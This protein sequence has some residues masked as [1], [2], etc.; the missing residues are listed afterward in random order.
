MIINMKYTK[1]KIADEIAERCEVKKFE[2]KDA[3]NAIIEELSLAL[4]EGEEIQLRR[5]GTFKIKDT[6]SRIGRNIQKGKPIKIPPTKV[7]K[8]KVSRSLIKE[9]DPEEAEELLNK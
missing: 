7:I 2:A 8:F 1:K 5:L 3:V 4:I 9:L 6:P